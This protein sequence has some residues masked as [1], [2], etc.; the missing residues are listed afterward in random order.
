MDDDRMPGPLEA[1]L[2]GMFD[3]DEIR[4]L[5]YR[6]AWLLDSRDL[7]A[8][9]MLFV[10]DVR[11][12]NTDVGR[13]ALRASFAAQLAT[14]GPTTL[15]VGNHIVDLD[16]S[17]PTLATGI[18]YCRGYIQEPDGFVEQMIVYSDRYRRVDR[19]WMFQG[20][21]H[22]LVYGVATAEHPYEQGPADWPQRSVGVGT[23]PFRLDT[24][25]RFTA[26]GE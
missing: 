15:F 26:T 8:L 20:R 19:T 6:Y 16:R 25:K 22:E 14:I 5:A 3:R 18:V 11:V 23:L 17:D 24:W 12:S 2:R 4:Q 7:D 1:E 21:R 9:V 10:D 13:D